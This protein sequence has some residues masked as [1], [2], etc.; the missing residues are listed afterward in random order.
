[1]ER[2]ARYQF[3]FHISSFYFTTLSFGS[4]RLSSA[5]K[6]FICSAP[7][8]Y[9]CSALWFSFS[10]FF[11]FQFFS[12]IFVFICGA[13]FKLLNFLLL[14]K[15]MFVSFILFFWVHAHELTQRRWKKS[16]YVF[17]VVACM[18][19]VFCVY[20]IFSPKNATPIFS[21][22]CFAEWNS[23]KSTQRW[24]FKEIRRKRQTHSGIPSKAYE[25][26]EKNACDT[27]NHDGK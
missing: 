4:V 27:P 14:L 18:R 3:T 1:M 24:N 21:F 20:L 26:E 13:L 7:F 6:T 5:A 8:I 10:V 17:F 9:S 25:Q 16:F 19:Y 12:C 22:V 2:R 11:S 15:L 23:R